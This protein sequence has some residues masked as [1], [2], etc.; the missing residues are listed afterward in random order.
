VPPPEENHP[1]AAQKAALMQPGAQ[2][3]QEELARGEFRM[4]QAGKTVNR[5]EP[6]VK[7]VAARAVAPV[8][9][10]LRGRALP[11]CRTVRRVLPGTALAPTATLHGLNAGIVPLVL[12]ASGSI[13]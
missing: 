2:F 9:R 4:A 10:F 1:A 11:L 13:R 5:V 12:G 6:A 3:P 8:V 7:E